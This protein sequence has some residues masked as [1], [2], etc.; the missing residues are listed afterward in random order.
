MTPDAARAAMLEA[1][2]EVAPEA[3]V[4]TL[5]PDSTFQEQLDLDSMDFLNFVVALHEL[6]GAEIPERDYPRMTTPDSCV[7]YLVEHAAR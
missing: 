5:L 6:T 4:T 2:G 3:D 1:L 7:A